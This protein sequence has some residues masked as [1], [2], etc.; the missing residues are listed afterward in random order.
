MPLP[1]NCGTQSNN[2]PLAL[3][4][5]H[6]SRRKSSKSRWRMGVKE[7]EGEEEGS[8]AYPCLTLFPCRIT[9]HE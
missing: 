7:E 8:R 5:Q 3:G 1:S 6:L 4:P 2:W 9:S